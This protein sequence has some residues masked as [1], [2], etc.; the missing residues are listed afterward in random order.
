MLV[1][2]MFYKLSHL[3]KPSVS[4]FGDGSQ[5]AAAALAGVTSGM[6]SH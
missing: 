4:V 1:W 3:S 6:F 5:M 2:C